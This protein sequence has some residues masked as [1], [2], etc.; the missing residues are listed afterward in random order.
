MDKDEIKKK[1]KQKFNPSQHQSVI[2]D[3][4]KPTFA[5]PIPTIRCTSIVKSGP[6]Q[7]KQCDKFAPAGS[8]VCL[9]HG[10]HLES[11]KKAAQQRVE[12][13]RAK[14]LGATDDAAEVIMQLMM[15]SPQDN[16]RLAAAKDILDRAGLKQA[17]EQTVHVEHTIK[18]SETVTERL[19][20]IAERVQKGEITVQSEFTNT[21]D[22]D[23]I[24]IETIDSE[25]IVDE[26]PIPD[27]LK[28]G[29]SQSEDQL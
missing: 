19:K 12:M 11:V 2:P 13:A 26:I 4:W 14:I 5:R 25:E 8:N 23:I 28:S 16:I 24:D 17:Q 18:A 10:Y 20:E 3:G 27:S 9:Q 6:N 22:S 29:N 21:E 15:F 1:K 7:G